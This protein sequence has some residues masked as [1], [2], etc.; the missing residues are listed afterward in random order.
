MSDHR[1]ADSKTT[2]RDAKLADLFVMLADTLVDDYDIVDVLD[3]LVHACR[4]FL[5][6]DEAGLLLVDS[7]GNLQLI[8]ST[9]EA[10]RLLELFQ[11]Q[12]HEGGPCV[13]SVRTGQTVSVEDLAAET[14]WPEFAAAAR[15]VGFSAVHAIPMRLREET[16]GGLN[17]L[18]TP[19]LPLS[20]ADQRVARALTDVA[21]IGILQ[22]RALDRSSVLAGQLQNALNSRIVIEQAKGF[23]AESGA[24]D[25]DA[26]FNLLRDYSRNHN[27]KL[28]LV[29]QSLVRRDLPTSAILSQIGPSR[30]S[31]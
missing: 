7:A 6:V 20:E 2:G 27:E 3:R 9:N 17:L 5:D 26:A 1:S 28:S 4:E 23:L 11:I 13:E 24:I 25:V 22:Q 12:S 15:S 30:G 19:G 18:S 14:R 8:A 21:T 29:A 31:S 16:I 10:T